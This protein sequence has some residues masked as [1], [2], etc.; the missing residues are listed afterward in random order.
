MN[1]KENLINSV[2]DQI[3]KDIHDRDYTALEEL[4]ASVPEDLLKGFLP[5]AYYNV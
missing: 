3:E 2:I 4:L 5:E 1:T